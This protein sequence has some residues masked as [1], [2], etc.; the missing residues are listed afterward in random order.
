MQK[1]MIKAL[2]DELK[3]KDELIDA[4]AKATSLMKEQLF[5]A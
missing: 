1:D 5:N 4:S 2:E 3:Q